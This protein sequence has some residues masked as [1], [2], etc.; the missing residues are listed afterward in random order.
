MFDFNRIKG[1]LTILIVQAVVSITFILPAYYSACAQ[2]N[3]SISDEMVLKIHQK[4]AVVP[5]A[6]YGSDTGAILGV[7]LFYFPSPSIDDIR[8]SSLDI[9]LFGTT[10][11]QFLITL[12]PDLYLDRGSYRLNPQLFGSYWTA[13]YYGIGN[14]LPDDPEDYD[15]K[16]IGFR[17]SLDRLFQNGFTLGPILNVRWSKIEPKPGGKME[18]DAPYGIVSDFYSGAGLA[19]GY[20]SRDNTNAPHMGNLIR[21]E[22]LNYLTDLGSDL[23]FRIHDVDLRHYFP[24]SE[25]TTF[26][27]S[28]KLRISRGRIPIRFLSK[29]DGIKILRG[30]ESGRSLDRDLV[31]LQSEFRYPITNKFSGTVFAEIAQVAPD[32][33]DFRIKQFTSSIGAGLR[34]SLHQEQR[35]NFRIDLSWVDDK[36][37]IVANVR[38]AF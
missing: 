29:P 33:T 13:S 16:N 32:L 1:V 17:L 35:L 11:G 30:T 21:Y 5:L 4:W 24:T 14:D 27:V 28:G 9:I 36:I 18:A 20:D 26:A 25:R 12:G 8:N 38:E 3:D 10:K 15:S 31:A 34:Y 2:Q 19:A 6:A 23:D 7:S 22:Y 37:G